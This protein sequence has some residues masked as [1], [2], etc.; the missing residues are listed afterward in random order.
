M[1]WRQ[2]AIRLVGAVGFVV[3]AVVG[4][5]APM[6][7]SVADA[8]TTTVTTTTST[9]PSW[10]T[11]PR[12]TFDASSCLGGRC[13]AV[14]EQDLSEQVALPFVERWVLT[15][16]LDGDDDAIQDGDRGDERPN[17]QRVG[18]GLAMKGGW[19]G[20]ER[21]VRRA[22]VTGFAFRY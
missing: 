22:F 11:F 9:T 13:V 4:M 21:L 15:D 1:H 3:L 14:G 19:V 17:D 20:S 16:T 6:S 2:F 5:G 10:D 18:G 7:A 12:V 8:V